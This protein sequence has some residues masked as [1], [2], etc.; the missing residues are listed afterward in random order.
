MF[1]K[2][3]SQVN[4]YIETHQNKMNDDKIYDDYIEFCKKNGELPM[5][6]IG[7]RELRMREEELKRK[8]NESM[9]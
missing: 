2:K 5:E 7:F 4:P 8:I 6:K 9:R 1:R 3:K